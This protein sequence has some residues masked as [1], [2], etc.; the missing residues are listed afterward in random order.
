ML[1]QQQSAGETRR[2]LPFDQLIQSCHGVPGEWSIAVMNS[3]CALL[4]HFVLRCSRGE[5][6]PLWLWC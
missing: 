4:G 3:G 6:V 5:S 1:F 2:V